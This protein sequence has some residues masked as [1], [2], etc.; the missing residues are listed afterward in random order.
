LARPFGLENGASS[1]SIDWTL[2]QAEVARTKRVCA[3]GG[4]EASLKF[5]G[6]WGAR[7]SG[8][9]EQLLTSWKPWKSKRTVIFGTNIC[10]Q[11]TQDF[12]HNTMISNDLQCVVRTVVICYP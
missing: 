1:F 3:L 12:V 2:V 9:I 4:A 5:E 7:A 11:T 6:E 10:D 8:Q